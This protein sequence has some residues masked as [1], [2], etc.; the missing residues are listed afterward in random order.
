MR[1]LFRLIGWTVVD[2]FRPRAELEAEIWTLRQQIN[3]L[4]RTAPKRLSFSILDR[5][6]FVGLYRLFPK[7]C[8]ALAIVKPDT[9]VRWH[10]AGFRLYW[11][12]KSRR[13]GGRPTVP[14]ETRKL[15]REMSIANPLWGAPRIHGELLK[16]GIDIGQTS[17]A[18]YMARRRGPPSQGWKTFLRNHAD[19]IAAMDLFVV[20]TISFR[21]LYGLL[22]VGH[23]RRHI[24]WFGVTSHPTAE[25]IA[26]QLTEACG[27]EQVPRYLIRD[28]DRAYR[29][30]FIRRLRSMGIRDRPTSPHSPWQNGYAERLIGSIRRECLDHVVVFGERHLRHMLQSYM[31]YYNEMR[32]HLSIEKDA[33]VARAVERTGHINCRPVLGGLHHQYVR[34]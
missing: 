28:R 6:V 24:L 18:K 10:R 2:L 19:G 1:D 7:I 5:L 13:P 3:V 32:T 29:D 27:W 9:I 22:I 26:N 31:K 11:C 16:L 23:G 17:V 4:R 12:W 21:L 20:P 34:I 8:D 25:W 14:L 30:I 15:I 33:P